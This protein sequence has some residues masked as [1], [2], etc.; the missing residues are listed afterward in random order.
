MTPLTIGTRIY[1]HGDMAN[2]SYFGTITGM[3]DNHYEITP[4]DCGKPAWVLKAMVSPEFKGHS[5][6]RIVTEAAY[7][8]WRDKRMIEVYGRG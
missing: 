6:T 3:N 7:H 4:D 5:G 2:P 8:A 1:N